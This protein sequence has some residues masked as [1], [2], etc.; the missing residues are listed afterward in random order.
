MN[1]A[2]K[3]KLPKAVRKRISRITE[4][5]PQ[6]KVVEKNGEVVVEIKKKP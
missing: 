6:A 3:P 2:N 1:A 5:F 4:K